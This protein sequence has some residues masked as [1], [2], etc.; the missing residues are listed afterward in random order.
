M[1]KTPILLRVV[2]LNNTQFIIIRFVFASSVWSVHTAQMPRS[3]SY[4]TL[5][6]YRSED[7][8]NG[9]IISVEFALSFIR[10]RRGEL[11]NRGRGY[12]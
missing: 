9:R 6:L 7:G 12:K 4:V 10:M 8:L 11:V 3:R 5:G 1:N 2:N